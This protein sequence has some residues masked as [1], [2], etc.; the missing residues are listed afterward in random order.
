MAQYRYG[1]KEPVPDGQG[2]ILRPLDTREFGEP[3][4]EPWELA[5]AAPQDAPPDEPPADDTPPA[6]A[7]AAS[8]NGGK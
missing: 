8:G 7:K 4:G 5:E 2:G 1:G 3:P 6:K